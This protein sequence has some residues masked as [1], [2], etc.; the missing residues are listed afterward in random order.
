MPKA[1]APAL[2]ATPARPAF[3][4]AA[5][6]TCLY[7]EELSKWEPE[8]IRR[9]ELAVRL[10]RAHSPLRNSG[11][12]P[13]SETTAAL[14]MQGQGKPWGAIYAAVIPNYA[15]LSGDQRRHEQEALRSRVHARRRYLRKQ[16]RQGG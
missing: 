12:P 14:E 16:S 4:S 5:A 2:A 15:A 8:P 3:G 11:R 10:V 6:A 1:N 7:L 13:S 9:R